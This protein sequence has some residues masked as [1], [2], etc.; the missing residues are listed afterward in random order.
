MFFFQPRSVN[1]HSFRELYN[2]VVLLGSK[3]CTLTTICLKA[4]EYKKFTRRFHKRIICD[5]RTDEPEISPLFETTKL[6]REAEFIPIVRSNK[7]LW[8]AELI[9]LVGINKL[10]R[11]AELIPLVG[12]NKL[13][14][15]EQH[16]SF[17]G[18]LE[19]FLETKLSSVMANKEPFVPPLAKI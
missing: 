3:S 6:L 1:W 16:I 12:T 17:Q 2:C 13:L 9:P 7:L 19:L 8:E 4:F 14:R 15:E 11:E 5:V 18:R 10:L